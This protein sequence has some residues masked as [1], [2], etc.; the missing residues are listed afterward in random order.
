MHKW[1][2]KYDGIIFDLDG[3]ICSTD[4]YHYLAWREIADEEGIYFDKEINSRL[5]GVS[6]AESLEIILENA[7]RIYTEQEK[8]FLMEKKNDIYKKYLEKMS[9]SD[10]SDEVADT[11]QKLRRLGCKL[12]IGSSSKNAKL[13]LG[14]LGLETFFDAISDGTNIKH[15]KP[16]PEVFEKAA[17]FLKLK[18]KSCLVVEDAKAGIKAATSGGFSSAGFGEAVINSNATYHMEQFSDLLK[19]I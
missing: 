10:L 7:K 3:V 9:E 8:K 18:P 6:R 2:R 4:K 19:F 1:E 15:S 17:Q 16:D 12:A 14:R 11:I 5:R 13:I